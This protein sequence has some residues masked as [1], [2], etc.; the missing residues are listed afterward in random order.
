MSV[1]AARWSSTILICMRDLDDSNVSLAERH[2][3]VLMYPLLPHSTITVTERQNEYRHGNTSAALSLSPV[4]TGF[5]LPLRMVLCNKR[6]HP[7]Y[8]GRLLRHDLSK[9]I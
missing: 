3:S 6:T 8:L 4:I 5:S 7:D 2:A 1:F 9:R